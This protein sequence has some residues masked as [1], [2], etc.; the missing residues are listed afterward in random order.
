MLRYRLLP[1]HI[2]LFFCLVLLPVLYMLL[3][4][5]RWMTS[6]SAFVCLLGAWLYIVYI[7]NRVMIVR[8]CFRKR[9]Y[10]LIALAAIAAGII[11]TYIFAQYQMEL[12]LHRARPF[13]RAT[14]R[15]GIQQQAV[16]FLY[17]IVMA[18]STAVGLLS[19][20]YRLSSARKDAEMEKK[21]AE[22]SIYKA[23]I[24]PHF[25]FNTLNTL[26]GMI[27]T[28]SDKTEQA[29]T[30]FTSLMKYMYSYSTMDTVPVE[31]E[32]Q[33][34][35]DYIS[36][37]RYRIPEHTDVHFDSSGDGTLQMGIIPMIMVTFV[38]NA[39]KHGISALHPGAIDIRI[40]AENGSLMFF[41]RNRTV[42]LSENKES[43]GIGIENCRRRLEL[44]YH[45]RY[46]LDISAKENVFSV[47]LNVRLK[48]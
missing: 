11:I 47:E 21:K 2:D 16:W 7:A 41:C 45:D 13:N 34:I 32:I 9:R 18:F 30:E 24:N 35:R 15:P 4:V 44:Q 36:L 10:K 25:L 6:N 17:I 12:P 22:L 23:Q 43:N 8:F 33:Y 20:V 40:T 37:Q 38:E 26:Y 28:G 46:S 27:V 31:T 14:V 42:N 29:F 19:E 3:P 1:I 5:E 39:F 48:A